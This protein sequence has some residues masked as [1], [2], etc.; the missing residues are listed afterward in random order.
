MEPQLRGHL[1]LGG[2]SPDDLS[3][4]D[5][6]D[7]GYV[8]MTKDASAAV[9]T[10]IAD[11]A[12]ATSD[13]QVKDGFERLSMVLAS[14][15]EAAAER[16][17]QQRRESGTAAYAPAGQAQQAIDDWNADILASRAEGDGGG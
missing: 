7:A 4:R 14:E 9:R 16:D 11:L 15:A 10:V 6:L 17:R 8:W 3:V 13:D 5:W 2:Q 12:S 1:I